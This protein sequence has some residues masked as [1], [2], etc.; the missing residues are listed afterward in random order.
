VID[1]RDCTYHCADGLLELRHQFTGLPLGRH[2]DEVGSRGIDVGTVKPKADVD[3]RWNAVKTTNFTWKF[4]NCYK[5]LA[6]Q[7]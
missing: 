2:D 1:L 7:W 5:L 6:I 4:F 3:A